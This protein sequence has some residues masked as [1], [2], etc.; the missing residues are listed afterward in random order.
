MQARDRATGVVTGPS[1]LQN[2]ILRVIGGRFGL[3]QQSRLINTQLAVK[4]QIPTSHFEAVMIRSLSLATLV[5]ALAVSSGVAAPWH[6]QINMDVPA[7]SS[8]G[9]LRGAS[10]QINGSWD[11]AELSPLLSNEYVTV[12]PSTNTTAS[13]RVVGSQAS[14]G[15]YLGEVLSSPTDG[16]MLEDAEGRTKDSIYFPRM[17]FRAGTAI[18]NTSPRA[19]FPADFFNRPGTVYPRS[20]TNG[21]AIWS[22]S[23]QVANVS[24]YASFVPEPNSFALA[25]V[26]LASI[27]ALRRRK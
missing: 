9:E 11:Y 15:I 13:L 21:Q 24:G 26:A 22:T 23:T 17:A 25:T 18:V 3:H 8:L 10:L 4:L 14:D 27:A 16:W 19:I 7:G 1:R 20:F 6:F 12:W 2:K 5:A